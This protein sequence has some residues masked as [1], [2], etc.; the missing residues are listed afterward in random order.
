[1]TEQRAPQW[2][3]GFDIGGTKISGVLLSPEG[4]VAAKARWPVPESYEAFLALIV[5]AVEQFD[6]QAGAVSSVGL[7]LAGLIDH[8]QGCLAMGRLT[9]LVGQP[10]VRD[11]SARLARPVRIANDADCFAVSEA[12]DG[13]GAAYHHVFGAIIGTG[14]GGAQ[15]IGKQLVT[16]ANGVNGEWGHLP[17]PYYTPADGVL[18]TCH[19]GQR[20]CVEQFVSGP[21]LV[22]LHQHKH[23]IPLSSE[24]I[25][26]Q[27]LAGE[28]AALATC[29]HFYDQVARA[30]VILLLCFD[31]DVIVIGGGLKDLPGICAAVRAKIPQHCFVRDLKTV[32]LPAL[33]DSDSGVRGAAWLV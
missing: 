22:R 30:F 29:D 25:A 24:E 21:G 5:A 3:I 31:P 17:L 8:Q 33:H 15:V 7:G 14:A 23:G 2:R 9:L 28:T 16:G 10:L 19:C 6:V 26:A 1:M 32:I 4:A 12:A 18:P 27:A 11:L 20:G 13:A